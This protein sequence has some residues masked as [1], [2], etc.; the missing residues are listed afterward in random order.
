MMLVNADD[1]QSG[2]FYR[3]QVSL[4]ANTSFEFITY[5]VTVNSQGDFDFCTANEGGLVLPN[6]TLQ[7]E[8]DSGT[9]LASFDTGDIPFNPTPDWEAYTLDFSTDATTTSINVVLINNSLGGCGNDLAI[10]DITFRVAVTMEAFDD[11]VTVADTT[12]AQ[13]AVIDLGDND[14]I[15]G[16][17]LTGTEL[18]YVATGST[19]PS[20]I[21]LNENTGEVD[22]AA[23][24]APG[25]YSF[26][27]EVCETS[28]QFNCDTAT[29]TIIISP[30][31]PVTANDDNGSVADTSAGF[32]AVLNVLDNDEIDSVT[33][34]TD[35]EL[36]IS[37]TSSLPAGLTFHT[38]TGEVGVNQG[39]AAGTY[40]F[41]YDLC[42][43][44][45]TSNC[46]SATVEIIVSSPS[47]GLVCP[48]G[49]APTPGTFHVVSATGEIQ[50]ELTVGA[51]FPEGSTLID[52][53]SAR[54]FYGSIFMDLTG[55]NNVIVPEGEL[56]EIALSTSFN[57]NALA[58]ILMSADGVTYTSLGTTGTGGSVYGAW[59][60][61]ISR[62]DDFTVPAGGA[63]YIEINRLQGGV[64]A[65]GVIYTS[66]CQEASAAIT[67]SKSVSVYDPNALNIYAT[68]GNDIIYTITVANAGPGN[69][70]ADSL[71]LVD[72]MPSEISFYN[73]DQNG[74]NG[75]EVD[76]VIFSDSGS[77][78]T[79]NYNSD[80][81]FSNA[82][83]PPTDFSA[84]N[85]TPVSSGYDD[86]ITHICFNPKGEMLPNSNWSVSFRARIN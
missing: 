21:T 84:C 73:D 67:A 63:R 61:N 2:E 60:S 64:R 31:P 45:N 51:P 20:G 5:L 79:F 52:D 30:P 11:S 86:T 40:I 46:D 12:T 7:I 28:N 38:A 22:V 53:N 25:T 69:A 80:V 82:A 15:D 74:T 62:Y 76:P 55:S 29:T 43:L 23:G 68:P 50:P 48:V 77:G 24:T 75:P 1:N 49:T 19:L 18:F 54:T 17:P 44:G 78:L 16:N 35:F 37:A 66:Q 6:V 81:G 26:V 83:A 14:T 9:V 36:S 59:S 33:P 3:R 32:T 47:G 34:P 42:E 27:Y 71:F 72:N 39:T 41:E 58:E 10:D 56:I 4:T 57:S 8:N 70:S 85:Y 65:D 13:N